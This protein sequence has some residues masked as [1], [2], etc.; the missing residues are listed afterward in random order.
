MIIAR[1]CIILTN[2]IRYEVFFHENALVTLPW[3]VF[4]SIIG[5]SV[6]LSGSHI[7]LNLSLDIEI[8]RAYFQAFL[9]YTGEYN[10]GQSLDNLTYHVSGSSVK[11]LFLALVSEQA[12]VSSATPRYFR[13]RRCWCVRLA[14]ARACLPWLYTVC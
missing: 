7:P 12:Y 9:N 14:Y 5:T 8:H 3:S 6:H 10:L 2:Y 1:F 4:V 13:T 11:M